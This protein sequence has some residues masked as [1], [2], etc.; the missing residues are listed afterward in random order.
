MNRAALRHGAPLGGAVACLVALAACRERY[1]IGDHVLVEYDE[2][3]CPAYVL[4]KRGTSRFRVHFDFEGYDWQ[5]DVAIDRV[6]GRATQ[7]TPPCPLPRAVRATLGLLSTKKHEARDSPYRV[8]ERVRVRWRG[9]TYPATI[10]ELI[11]GDQLR[12]HYL[13]HESVWD[14]AISVDR[15]VTERH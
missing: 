10:T 5:D 9:S 7:G 4:E 3:R 1:R 15:I 13:G 12:V 6:V 8:G 11:G 14:E 2:R